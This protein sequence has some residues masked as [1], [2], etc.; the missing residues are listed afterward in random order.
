VEAPGPDFDRSDMAEVANDDMR[1]TPI[2]FI[3]EWEAGALLAFDDLRDRRAVQSDAN[4]RALRNSRRSHA[5]TLPCNEPAER[6]ICVPEGAASPFKGRCT[7]TGDELPLELERTSG[8]AGLNAVGD[9]D[10][11]RA[12][13][14]IFSNAEGGRL[15]IPCINDGECDS[16]ASCSSS[17][18][19][20]CRSNPPADSPSCSSSSLSIHLDTAENLHGDVS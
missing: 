3:D 4:P 18:A 7:G 5:A 8:L 10:W 1:N 9:A 13:A 14:I 12:E 11:E 19:V 2:D 15:S 17:S 6:T 20:D 16:S